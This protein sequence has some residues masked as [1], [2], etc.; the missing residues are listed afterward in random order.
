MS[1]KKISEL[2]QVGSVS[3]QKGFQIQV[4]KEYALGLTG[5]EGFSHVQIVW[6]ADRAPSWENKMLVMPSPY[7]DAPEMGVFATRSP[8]RPNGI[9]ISNAE[10]ISV[11]VE[12]GIIEL[13]WIDAEDGTP[14]LDIKPYHPSG[15]KIVNAKIPS[16]GKSWPKSFEESG[17]FD[18]SKVFLF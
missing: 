13:T 15:D 1:G 3:T 17:D 11:D 6:Y 18:W 16:W 10:V 12:N 7:K 8:L 5:L 4:Q 9:C 2:S 14:V